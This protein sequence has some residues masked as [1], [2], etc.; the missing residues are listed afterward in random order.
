MMMYGDAIGEG[1]ANKTQFSIVG[2][3]LLRWNRAMAIAHSQ[4]VAY[5]HRSGRSLTRLVPVD[6]EFDNVSSCFKLDVAP[7]LQR[8]LFDSVRIVRPRSDPDRLALPP[9]PVATRNG[10]TLAP[11]NLK[12]V[13]FLQITYKF[14]F[15]MDAAQC[16]PEVPRTWEIVKMCVNSYVDLVFE[17]LCT[18]SRPAQA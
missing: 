9:V 5:V 11:T 14:A 6:F 18:Q 7:Y 17:D 13:E 2:K 12:D 10:L 16:C 3:I 1:L 15:R 4:N 8:A